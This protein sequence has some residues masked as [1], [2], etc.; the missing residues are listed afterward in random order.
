M[1]IERSLAVKIQWRRFFAEPFYHTEVHEQGFRHDPARVKQLLKEAGYKGETIVITTNKRNA[2][3]FDVAIIAQAML[4]AAG[5][6]AEVE[7]LEWGA[8]QDRWQNGN[9][10][11]PVGHV[12]FWV[13]LQRLQTSFGLSVSGGTVV[14]PALTCPKEPP[15]VGGQDLPDF[16]WSW[17]RDRKARESF[18][19]ACLTKWPGAV[20]TSACLGA[21]QSRAR[22]GL[23]ISSTA[24]SR[25]RLR[26]VGSGTGTAESNLRV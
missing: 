19:N 20:S 8:Q 12:R 18:H 22:I 14:V 25:R 7:V 5:I 15:A 2:A 16:T 23:G 10:Q 21:D 9:Y 6:K 13:I 4:Q 17:S 1:K 3:N 24:S 11:I 26:R